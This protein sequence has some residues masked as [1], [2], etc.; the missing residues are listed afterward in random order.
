MNQGI[1]RAGARGFLPAITVW[2][3]A[4]WAQELVPPSAS[5]FAVI[6]QTINPSG[7]VWSALLIFSAWAL[8]RF[9]DSMVEEMGRTNA[10]R[11]LVLQRLNA[12][13]HF[14][15]YIATIATVI[16]LSFKISQQVRAL[17]ISIGFATRDLLASL[18]AGVMIIFDR[19]FQVGDRVRF[20]GEYGDILA[21]GLRSV[22]LR[23]LDDSIVTIPNNLFLSEVA[24]SSNAGALDMQ[25]VVDF[26]I[27]IDQDADRAMKLVREA[28]AV[29]R[30]TFLSKPIVVR[31]K[32]VV[33]DNCIALRIRLKAYVLDTHHEKAFETDITLRVQEAFREHGIQPPA[34]LHR[35]SGDSLL[36]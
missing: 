23:T 7:L 4:A 20:G 15:V 24:A 27:G 14:F 18:V 31:V 36:N 12:I 30:Y 11:R 29:G 34:V 19:P 16:L 26:Y 35:S 32:Q 1:C 28:A 13:F 22:K 8:L 3:Q 6:R 33:L 21:I 25:V 17:F 2:S 5:D 9:V 10:E